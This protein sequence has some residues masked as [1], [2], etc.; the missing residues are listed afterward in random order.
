MLLFS[1]SLF[2]FILS[3]LYLNLNKSYIMEFELFS[4]CSTTFTFSLILDKISV[5]FSMVVTLISG[6][7]FFFSSKYMEEDPFSTRFIMILLA[8]VISMNF[9]IF[10]GSVFFLLVGWDGLGITSFAL[11]IYYESGESQMAG[12]QTLM[13]NRL[14]DVIIVV[15]MYL[16]VSGGQFT[17]FSLSDSFFYFSGVVLLLCVAALTKSAQF[18]FSSWLPAAMAAPTPVSALVHS[19]TLVTAGIYLI[20]R[21][22]Q[23]S[24][25]SDGICSLLLLCGSVTCLL[26]GWAATYENDI[27]KVIALSTLSQLGVMVFSLGLNFPS[28]AL[29]HL[30]THALFKALL[31][32]AAGHILMMTFGSQD[33]RMIGGLGLSMPYTSL[34]FTVSSLCLIGAPFMSAFYSKHLILEI[35][36]SSKVNLISVIIMLI[37]TLMTAKYVFRTLKGVVWGKTSNSLISGCS[38]IY[39]FIPVSILGFG[40]VVGGEFISSLEISNL[41]SAFIPSLH[42]TLVNLVTLTGI[43]LGLV[44]SR[45]EIKS[46][47]LSTLFFLTPLVYGSP[48]L[49]SKMVSIVGVLDYGWLEPYFIIKNKIYMVGSSFSQE[50]SWPNSSLVISLIMMLFLFAIATMFTY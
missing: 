3:Y 19:S 6:S 21:L 33:V 37:A 23:A 11:I 31:F 4:L 28:L 9:L 10:S 47:A 13:I 41:E 48:K 7:V 39:T 12:F 15:S 27:K 49:F 32:L 18:P 26:G 29:F 34:M 46:F 8:F 50:G 40:A 14:G 1:Y 30:Y 43:S 16:F 22:S 24:P 42:S 44:A 38:D 45:Y 25:L 20:I 2:M 17:I 36:M 5:S 35:M